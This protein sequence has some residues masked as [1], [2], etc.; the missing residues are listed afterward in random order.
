MKVREAEIIAHLWQLSILPSLLYPTRRARKYFSRTAVLSTSR[1]YYTGL[2]WVDPPNLILF[3]SLLLAV[4][5]FEL[6]AY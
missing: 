3:V 6:S 4:L 5:G 2:F 1:I